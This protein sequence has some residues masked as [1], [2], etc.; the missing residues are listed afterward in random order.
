MLAVFGLTSCRRKSWNE[1]SA[2]REILKVLNKR[3][4]TEFVVDSLE[5]KNIGQNFAHYVYAANVHQAE[6]EVLFEAQLDTDGGNVTDNYPKVLYGD[7]LEP[8]AL[9]II[10]KSGFDISSFELSY[11]LTDEK[12]GDFE[13]YRKGFHVYVYMDLQTEEENTGEIAGSL[14]QLF[15]ELHDNGFYYVLKLKAEE[16][17]M[18]F[19]HSDT[20]DI[21]SEEEIRNEI[22]G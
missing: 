11:D 6:T 14:E 9:G 10:E 2:N 1:E 22:E 21:P 20:I 16:R 7:Q 17:E 18:Y 15:Q 3:Y 12:A 4:Q 19:V 5:E 8:L 13:K